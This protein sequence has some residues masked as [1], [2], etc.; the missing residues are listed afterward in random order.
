MPRQHET[1]YDQTRV[2]W[3]ELDA[4]PSVPIV[5]IEADGSVEAFK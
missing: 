3:H 4:A 5:L 1:V 2:V